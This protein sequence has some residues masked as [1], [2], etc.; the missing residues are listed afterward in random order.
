MTLSRIWLSGLRQSNSP[1]YGLLR[2]AV[3]QMRYAARRVTTYNVSLECTLLKHTRINLRAAHEP[4]VPTFL[5]TSAEGGSSPMIW[6]FLGFSWLCRGSVFAARTTS[7]CAKGCARNGEIRRLW[8]MMHGSLGPAPAFVPPCWCITEWLVREIRL[9]ADNPIKS[10]HHARLGGSGVRTHGGCAYSSLEA[11]GITQELGGIT[12]L[13]DVKHQ[14]PTEE[15][16]S[17]LKLDCVLKNNTEGIF[18]RLPQI[19]F[20]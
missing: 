18:P 11:Q 17:Q 19:H 7:E 3:I 6:V 15:S 20:Q 13:G 16:V 8:E 5:S 4:C 9:C 2:R 10:I 1:F 12:E 14:Q